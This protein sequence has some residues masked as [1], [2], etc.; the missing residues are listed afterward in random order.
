[1]NN[2]DFFL[3]YGS[4]N[5]TLRAGADFVGFCLFFRSFFKVVPMIV[6]P[7]DHEYL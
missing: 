5:F 3:I 2:N 6:L 1:M 4:C 7:A